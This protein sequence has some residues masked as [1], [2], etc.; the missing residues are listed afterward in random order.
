MID[1]GAAPEGVRTGL[2][3]GVHATADEVGL[4]DIVGGDHDLKFFDGVDGDRVATA[5]QVGAQTEVVVE[6]GTVHGEVGHTAVGTGE[7]HA[8][9]AIRRKA[10]HIGDGAADTGQI[11]DLLVGDV[12]GSTG[13]LRREFRRSGSDDDGLVEK[14]S[15]GLHHHVLLVGFSQRKDDVGNHDGLATDQRIGHFVRTAGTHTL[16]GIASVFVG[17]RIVRR[18]G[19]GV[20]CNHSRSD[21][22]LAA[23]IDDL[24]RE[25]GRCD[26]AERRG[27]HQQEGCDCQKTFECFFHKGF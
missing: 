17:H 23:L 22:R 15:G 14:F 13:L 5:R 2:G 11:G 25:V 19:R 1:I 21:Q 27:N 8:I 7:A 9:A 20:N 24:A 10:R 12:R 18:T 16:D 4:A 3:D 26:L 6:V